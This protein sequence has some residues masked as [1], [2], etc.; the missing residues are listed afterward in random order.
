VIN[1]K[2][3]NA[4]KNRGMGQNAKKISRE[5]TEAIFEKSRQGVK[6]FKFKFDNHWVYDGEERELPGRVTRWIGDIELTFKFSFGKK[7]YLAKPYPKRTTR[8]TCKIACQA[9]VVSVR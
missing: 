3:A 1:D 4:R 7:P 6:N 8:I 2:P 5:M 9:E